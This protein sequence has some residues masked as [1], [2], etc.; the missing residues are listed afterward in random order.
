M[1][2]ADIRIR[3]RALPARFE[4]RRKPPYNNYNNN[5]IYRISVYSGDYT[6]LRIFYFRQQTNDGSPRRGNSI[7]FN[8]T[9][10]RRLN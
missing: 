2:F 1:M 10:R 4:T 5:N 7:Y 3:S 8:E 9:G 6:G